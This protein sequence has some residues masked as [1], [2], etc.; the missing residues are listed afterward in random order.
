MQS[1]AGSAEM[2][3]CRTDTSTAPVGSA[4][5]CGTE[6]AQELA[7]STACSSVLQGMVVLR[8]E[9]GS[10][11]ELGTTEWAPRALNPRH[12]LQMCSVACMQLT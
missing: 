12:A 1:G 4:H 3:L 8:Q 6:L 11:E 7:G 9:R 5:I 2:P 10:L